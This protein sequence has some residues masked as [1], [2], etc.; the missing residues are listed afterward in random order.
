MFGGG[1]PPAPSSSTSTWP[2]PVTSTRP[3]DAPP[4]TVFGQS[5]AA[6]QN[7]LFGQAVVPVFGQAF[8]ETSTW[9]TPAA[10]S[11]DGFLSAAAAGR[12][13]ES[14]GTVAVRNTAAAAVFGGAPAA[15]KRPTDVR[16]DA[17]SAPAPTPAPAPA[18]GNVF[19]SVVAAGSH[20]V[21]ARTHVTSDQAAVGNAPGLPASQML[22]GKPV[23][24]GFPANASALVQSSRLFSK[25][26]SGMPHADDTFDYIFV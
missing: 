15:V 11:A 21:A 16:P 25:T 8:A 19:G 4:R 7:S 24:A 18:H 12:A 26:D 14:F 2:V 5:A 1:E 3:G 23:T 9:P 6:A 17:A 20:F 22:F 10:A 13:G